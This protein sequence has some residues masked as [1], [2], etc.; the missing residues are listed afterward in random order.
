MGSSWVHTFPLN[1]KLTYKLLSIYL[2]ALDVIDTHCEREHAILLSKLTRDIF[3]VVKHLA[4]SA[5]TTE[6]VKQSTL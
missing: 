3:R 5:L 1:F 2:M 4:C 6:A